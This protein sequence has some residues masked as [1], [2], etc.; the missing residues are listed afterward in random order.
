MKP[1][2]LAEITREGDLGGEKISMGFDANSLPHLYK[3]LVDLY[4]DQELA[5]IREYSTN[6]F[7]S[8]IDAGITKPIE[9]T[10]P[11]AFNPYFKIKDY[12]VGMDAD[13]IRD[14]Y[15]KFG[16]STKRESDAFNGMLGV[17]CKAGLTY[18]AQ[19][20]V[21]AVKDG[22]K[23]HV[24]VSRN[25]DGSGVMEVINVSD[26][27]E[28]NGVEIAIPVKRD[29]AFARKAKH[30]FSFWSE[31]TVL[32]DGAEPVRFNGEKVGCNS[33]MTYDL[34]QDYV[35]MGNV[36]YPVG[37]RLFTGRYHHNAFK[38]VA[39]VPMGSV[40][41][42]PS[43]EALLYNDYTSKAIEKIITEFRQAMGD[44]ISDAISAAKT[45]GE[46][47]EEYMEWNKKVPTM[48]GHVTYKGQQIKTSY[49]VSDDVFKFRPAS[50]KYAT[51]KEDVVD[52]LP[53]K[54]MLMI[55]G[56]TAGQVTATH[57]AKIRKFLA[58]TNRENKHCLL[59]KSQIG[60]PWTDDFDIVSWAEVSS[61][62]LERSEARAVV[63]DVLTSTGRLKEQDTFDT[64]RPIYY[65]SPKDKPTNWS[66]VSAS[67]P[68]ATV[69]VLSSNR[70]DKFLK[71]FPKAIRLS[72]A[73][74][75]LA[76]KVVNDLTE[77][78]KI[79]YVIDWTTRDICKYLNEN[80]VED[81]ELKKVIAAVRAKNGSV[82]AT[83]K[84][85]N[86]AA[87]LMD[88]FNK[89]MPK[90]NSSAIYPLERYPLLSTH[91]VIRSTEHCHIY[92]NTIYQMSQG[93]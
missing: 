32:I 31:G 93:V 82:T 26:T 48:L 41:F 88:A 25:T 79:G 59:S 17:G 1:V 85:Y 16:A 6:A 43:R 18:T 63:Y 81:P 33:Y 42:A 76:K 13:T 91:T 20:L 47:V 75:E 58:D 87:S 21:T 10:T 60:S 69:V 86:L 62:K 23:T 74:D 35:V 84:S 83:M 56:F 89:R 46:A 9:I 61:T 45:H 92:V 4:S 39:F 78:D 53:M 15:S 30:F 36:A 90:I 3:I 80:V 12:G 8:H 65:I 68:D 7:D 71:T 5:C 44:K 67:F 29:N 54:K 22:I 73:I 77:Q 19:F 66:V 52:F 28:C 70:W 38:V 24:S 40:T 37:N 64:S 50:N 72:D 2:A 34:E 14:V 51:T 57:R 55:T 27:D 49:I 11:N